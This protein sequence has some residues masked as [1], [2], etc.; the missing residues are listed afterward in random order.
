MALDE[1]SETFVIQ[2]ASLYLGIHPDRETQIATLLIEEV[3]I[4]EKY[5]DFTNVFSEEKTLVL[6]E[7]TELNEYAINLEDGKQPLYGLIHSLGPVELKTLKI[8]IGIH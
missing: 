7:C 2:M 6:L 5:S 8:Y 3:K 1:N 4:L